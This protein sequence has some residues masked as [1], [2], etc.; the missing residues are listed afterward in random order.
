VGRSARRAPAAPAAPARLGR[1]GR[2]PLGGGRFPHLV[3]C[4]APVSGPGAP[5]HPPFRCGAGGGRPAGMR[6]WGPARA[7]P[8]NPQGTVRPAGA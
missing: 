4:G 6:S 7:G 2:P 8:A 5:G 1:G 3:R